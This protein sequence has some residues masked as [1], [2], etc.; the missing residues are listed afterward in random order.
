M[1]PTGSQDGRGIKPLGNDECRLFLFVIEKHHIV[2]L[3]TLK[4]AK[5][6]CKRIAPKADRQ[7]EF[8]RN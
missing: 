1:R 2:G 6:D 5:A 8:G 4:L 3:Q 7:L